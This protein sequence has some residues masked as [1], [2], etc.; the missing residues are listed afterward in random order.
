MK[1]PALILSLAT[2]AAASLAALADGTI[3]YVRVLK[4]DA[5]LTQNGQQAKATQDAA[6]LRGS[7]IRTEA[8][9][10][11]G[12]VLLD[13]T[14][15]ALGP[16]SELSLDEFLYSPGQNRFVLD[17][18]LKR[19]TLSYL[20]GAI[21]QHNPGGVTVKTPTGSVGVRGSHFAIK[22]DDR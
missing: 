4:G 17:A 2:L 12:L 15:M 19:G 13:N 18:A 20:A 7:R 22:V 5:Y 11:L 1:L 10:S 3:G 9:A 14:V 21:A 8:G 16:G 6:L